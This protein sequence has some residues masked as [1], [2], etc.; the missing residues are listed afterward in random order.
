[1]LLR[2]EIENWTSFRDAVQLSLVATREKQHAERLPRVRKYPVRILPAAA[3]YGPNASGKSNL[4]RAVR[5]CRQFIVNGTKPDQAIAVQP[6]LLDSDSPERPSRF[7][8]EILVH[9][10][11]YELA[12]T[13]SRR[14]VLAES[15]V[16]ISSS[17]EVTLYSR[18]GGEMRF[19]EGLKD[20][21]FLEF[22]FRGTR[23][24]ELF[25]TNA[26]SQKLDVFRPIYEW[27]SRSLVLIEP[28]SA[29]EPFELLADA[30]SPLSA[31]V[32]DG[33][34]RLD[35]G[36]V[37]LTGKETTL[38]A[39]GLPASVVEQIRNGVTSEVSMRL[40]DQRTNERYFFSEGADGQIVATRIQAC[41]KASDGSKVWLELKSE[42]DGT[43]RVI[44]LLPAFY[45]MMDALSTKVF[46]IDE[47]DRSL[48]SMLTR[49][50]VGSFLAT[51]GPDSRSQLVFTTHDL[52]LMDQS[53]L[54]RD[55]MWI[56]SRE[57]DNSD[58]WSLADYE[59]IRYD[60][61]IRKSYILGRLG[62]IPR[63]LFHET[64]ANVG[65]CM[66]GE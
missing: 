11:I 31:R 61:D 54:R 3:I 12:F 25:L 26:V 5:F 4:F 28:D 15:L 16:R 36:V 19:D 59:G 66:Q 41:H 53:I 56:T 6:F 55:E 58:L 64:I 20:Q 27:F 14:A 39:I 2:L 60:R 18:E 24:N 51:A 42:S 32:A 1:M 17:S 45:D 62:G 40:H 50:L 8:F 43:Q 46:M 23:D 35:T 7:V 47:L 52:M 10:T 44:D 29:F 30:E 37:G 49:E 13:V 21:E 9:E 65:S 63:L 48:H 33:L 34:Q 57:D 22:A 38:E